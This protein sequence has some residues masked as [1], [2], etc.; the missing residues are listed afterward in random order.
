MSKVKV[1]ITSEDGSLLEE[2]VAM[3][4]KTEDNEIALARDIRDRLEHHFN[5]PWED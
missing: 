2:F 3:P 4:H 1:T 5:I